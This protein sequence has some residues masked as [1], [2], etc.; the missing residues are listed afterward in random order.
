MR[1][2]DGQRRRPSREW[3]NSHGR[4]PVRR[5]GVCVLRRCRDPGLTACR[6]VR[7]G[8][9]LSPGRGNVRRGL[10]RAGVCVLQRV[11]SGN[12]GAAF[13]VWEAPSRRP[14]PGQPWP[15]YTGA[16]RACAWMAR[17][18]RGRLNLVVSRRH[19]GV[20]VGPVGG[21][22]LCCSVRRRY[23]VCPTHGC[24]LSRASNPLALRW[25]SLFRR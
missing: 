20:A 22:N 19:R 11:R 16:S 24:G 14:N 25:K 4:G 1:G 13:A 15:R 3:V 23:S 5:A 21:P 6:P 8:P 10:C 17:P 9:R 18:R 7:L 12:P 2:S